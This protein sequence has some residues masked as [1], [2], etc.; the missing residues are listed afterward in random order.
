MQKELD[1]YVAVLLGRE[2]S[3]T[4][5]TVDSLMEYASTVLARA[6]EMQM[7]LHRAESEGIVPRGSH[8]Y[9]FRTGE[10]RAF[11]ELAHRSAELGSRR[12]TMAKME[13]DQTRSTLD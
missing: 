9:K 13:D 5:K 1:G 3:P 12:I 10:L 8:Y 7:L 4:G 6:L 2:E 11:I